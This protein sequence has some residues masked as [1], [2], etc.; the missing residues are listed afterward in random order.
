[1]SSDSPEPTAADIERVKLAMRGRRESPRAR[2]LRLK[3]K[4]IRA[5]PKGERRGLERLYAEL[6]SVDPPGS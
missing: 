4:Q 1:M 2:D 5:L 3:I 6:R